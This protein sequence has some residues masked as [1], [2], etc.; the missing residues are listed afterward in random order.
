MHHMATPRGTGHHAPAAVPSV[1]RPA[2]MPEI[3]GRATIPPKPSAGM[4][5]PRGDTHSF[6]NRGKESRGIGS[7]SGRRYP[8]KTLPSADNDRRQ[9]APGSSG[10]GSPQARPARESLQPPRTPSVT[11]GGYRG[12]NEARAQSLRGQASRQ[13]SAGIR[14]SAAPAPAS[15]VQCSCRQ[16][17]H[18]GQSGQTRQGGQ[19]RI[20]TVAGSGLL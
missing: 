15:K 5:G 8:L 11:F 19:K 9:P 18:R 1:G 12:A 13:S 14:P 4:F 16:D 7:S 10:K 2:R 17:C 3:R 20:L 6:S